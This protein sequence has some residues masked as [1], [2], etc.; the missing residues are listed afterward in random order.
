MISDIEYICK[1]KLYQM[2]TTKHYNKLDVKICANNY[3]SNI[4]FIICSNIY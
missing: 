1:M 2:M 4:D 3:E